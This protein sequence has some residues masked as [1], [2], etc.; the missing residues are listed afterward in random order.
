MTLTQQIIKHAQR[1]T[2][3]RDDILFGMKRGD[4]PEGLLQYFYNVEDIKYP[5]AS[6]IDQAIDY[7]IEEAKNV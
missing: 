1:Y 5:T 2:F 3:L 7:L 4:L 6:D